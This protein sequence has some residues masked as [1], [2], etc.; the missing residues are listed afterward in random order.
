MFLK[1][2]FVLFYF[3]IIILKYIH[4]KDI[5]MKYYKAHLTRRLILELSAEN[6]KEE[7]M[8]SLLRDVGMP[9]DFV[10]KLSR[11]F[12]DMKISQDFT[13]Q[14]RE[15]SS[16]ISTAF[17]PDMVSVKILNS[18]AWCRS[19][20]KFSVQ[21]PLQINVSLL[22]IKEFYKQKYAGRSLIWHHQLSSGLVTYHS[23]NGVYELELNAYQLSVL[24]CWND[25]PTNSI[26]L[27]S[28]SIRTSLPIN[29]LKRTLWV[30]QLMV[31]GLTFVFNM[32]FQS[33]T[34]NPKIKS[35]V[36]LIDGCSE[37][38]GTKLKHFNEMTDST[39]FCLNTNFVFHS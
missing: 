5:F 18:S 29:E 35:Q 21:L 7:Q 28:L 16:S 20:E 37:E 1:T 27:E 22:Q 12:Q 39:T 9:A 8:V 31:S 4:D 23:D 2:L 3:Q 11:M 24:C 33:L 34:N 13:Q 30:S 36:L 15:R 17:S 26:S 6:E 38:S 19:A 25:S 32:F 14:F 10:N